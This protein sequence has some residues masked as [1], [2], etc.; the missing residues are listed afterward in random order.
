MQSFVCSSDAISGGD[1]RRF[2]TA[3]ESRREL[4]LH[5]LVID[6][7]VYKQMIYELDECQL[8]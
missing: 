1:K 8:Y 4:L 5:C 7:F 6:G 2:D 3:A